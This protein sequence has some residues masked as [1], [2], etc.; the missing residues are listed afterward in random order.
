[1]AGSSPVTAVPWIGRG[2]RGNPKHRVLRQLRAL[3]VDYG[4]HRRGTDRQDSELLEYLDRAAALWRERAT[5]DTVLSDLPR[6]ERAFIVD[7]AFV[8][9]REDEEWASR[10]TLS[11]PTAK[12]AFDNWTRWLKLRRE[13]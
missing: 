3:S 1:M 7:G 6:K 9:I 12:R 2:R 13:G 11:M 10:P 5:L 8:L 4:D